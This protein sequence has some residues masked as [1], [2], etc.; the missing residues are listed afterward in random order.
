MSASTRSIYLETFGCQMN[1]LDSQLVSSQ[2]RT[3]GYQFTT[4]PDTAS[5]VLYNTCSVR[6]HAEQKVWSRLGELAIRKAR[7][8]GLVVGVLGCM[9]EREGDALIKRMPVVDILIGPGELD[10][11]PGLLD[12]AI[13]TRLSLL[14][15]PDTIEMLATPELRKPDVSLLHSARQVALQG[16]THRR[17]ATLAAASDNL[18]LLDL[19]RAVSPDDHSG[20]A[21]VRITRGC[22]KFCT[23]CVVP[24][25]RGAEVH[26]P[27]QHIIDECKKL[28]DAGVREITL[29]G[30]TVNHYRF[31]GDS[32]VTIDGIVQP[33]KGRVYKHSKDFNEDI[34]AG[35]GVTTFAD[36]LYQIHEQVP[37]LARLR[38]VTSFPRSFGDDVLKVI[39]DCPRICRYLHVPAQT[40]SNRL[41]GLM[42]RGYTIEEYLEFLDRARSFLHQPEINRPLTIA[43]DIIVGFPT[44]TEEDHLATAELLRKARYKN[45]FIFKY[46]PRPGTIAIDR[47]ADDV[48]D[49]VKR[50]R[51]NELLALQIDISHSVGGEFVGQT[52]D[53]FVQGVSKRDTR[54]RNKAHAASSPPGSVALTLGGKS[55]ANRAAADDD[56]GCATDASATDACATDASQVLTTTDDR[57]NNTSVQMSARTEGDLITFFDLPRGHTADDLIGTTVTVHIDRY[58]PLALYGTPVGTVQLGQGDLIR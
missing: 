27:P 50:R 4:D 16:N 38:F 58:D 19:G 11:L 43:G 8:P 5:V 2:L 33:Q 55:L 53:V 41:L 39:R 20:S 31:E 13:K 10:K 7:E 29:L 26:R 49:E 24:F 6:E 3:L 34:Y 23:Y 17:S 52:L 28:A 48:P 36:L 32:A 44:E 40:G 56:R 18:E 45:C 22:N 30:Q 35:A 42:N 46:S 12:N 47:F 57:A 14:D 9:A 15:H 51:N 1:E 37:S 21:Y 25:T 54:K